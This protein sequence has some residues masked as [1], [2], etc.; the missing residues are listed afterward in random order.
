MLI[1]HGGGVC[2]PA[3][4]KGKVLENRFK[5]CTEEARGAKGSNPHTRHLY[6]GFRRLLDLEQPNPLGNE[7]VGR[8]MDV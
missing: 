2:G 5:N 4:D 1:R 8:S 7:L 3:R 6:T